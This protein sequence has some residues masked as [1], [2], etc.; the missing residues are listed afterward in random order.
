MAIGRPAPRLSGEWLI[1][2]MIYSSPREARAPGFDRWYWD[3][4]ALLGKA[5]RVLVIAGPYD[6]DG[7]IHE[8]LDESK[9]KGLS[10]AIHFVEEGPLKV[11]YESSFPTLATAVEDLETFAEKHGLPLDGSSDDI[12][13]DF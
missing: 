4:L 8:I 7:T 9:K 1:A 11:V 10:V 2:T 13:F 12:T 3:V 5:R 6:S